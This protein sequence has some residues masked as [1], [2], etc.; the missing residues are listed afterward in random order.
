VQFDICLGC[1]IAT[2]DF[3]VELQYAENYGS[4]NGDATTTIVGPTSVWQYALG[5]QCNPAITPATCRNWTGIPASGSFA[6][7]WSS[8]S[9]WAATSVFFSRDYST[10]STGSSWTRITLPL[11]AGTGVPGRRYRLIVQRGSSA[12]LAQADW[13][14]TNLYIGGGCG[15]GCN[16]RGACI[17]GVCSC[18]PSFTLS[19]GTCV[20]IRGALLTEF[21]TSFDSTVLLRSMWNAVMGGS[22]S[23][24]QVVGSGNS[25]YFAG[26]NGARRAITVDLNTQAAEFLEF[27][28]FYTRWSSEVVLAYS[29]NGGITWNLLTTTASITSQVTM[30]FIIPLVGTPAQSP[31][32]RF[33]WWQP[34]Y[35]GASLDTWAIDDIY[36]GPN[37]ARPTFIDQTLG[38]FND[39]NI[40]TEISNGVIRPY[41]GRDN[42]VVM[43]NSSV[44]GQQYIEF[45]PVNATG[46]VFVQFDINAGCGVG[47]NDFAVEVH[48]ADNYGSNNGVPTTFAA[49]SGPWRYVLPTPCNPAL[50]SPVCTTWNAPAAPGR[51]LSNSWSYSTSWIGGGVVFSK[52]LVLDYW[53]NPVWQRVTLPLTFTAAYTGR[54]FRIIVQ[55]RFLE[56]E[57]A[58]TNVYIGAACSRECLEHGTCVNGTCVCDDSFTLTS[59]GA[60]MPTPGALMAEL[61]ET[62]END[63]SAQQ[64][65]GIGGCIASTAQT[66]VNGRSLVCDMT[67]SRILTTRDMD[68]TI[69][70]FIQLQLLMG[71][72][73]GNFPVVAAYSTDGGLIWN[74]LGTVATSNTNTNVVFTL[75]ID[76]RTNATRFRWWQPLYQGAA[77]NIWVGTNIVLL[78]FVLPLQTFLCI[79]ETIE[80][81]LSHTTGD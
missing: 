3:T 25:L 72:L 60:C 81:F 63:L 56:S 22:V 6:R 29:T 23:S 24:T 20:P 78:I 80:I 4:N 54:R 1:G 79:F 52:D 13:A 36:I 11:P 53:S 50:S 10:D 44:S 51:Y 9:P 21:S 77:Q 48:F 71:P 70:E 16:G 55:R 31:A 62:F 49:N 32:T 15:G 33:M 14:I 45:A 27:S 17:N 37:R 43:T 73:A 42:A 30:Q 47:V 26:T 12:P 69:G 74:T 61:R 41:C 39:T 35:G 2:G 34:L 8:S 66:V 76:A 65:L 5:P 57:W 64:W 67:A 75:P 7:E 59:G 38:N 19:G 40:V 68:M 28:M 18:D 46:N 58:V